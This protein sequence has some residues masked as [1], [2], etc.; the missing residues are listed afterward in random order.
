MKKLTI[1][2]PTYNRSNLLLKLF[3]LLKNQTTYDFVWH[4]IN[5]GSSDNTDK[6]VEEIIA[7]SP[8]QVVY[9]KQINSG[10]MAAWNISIVK[11]NTPFWTCID[12]D[13]EPECDFVAQ[14]VADI[15]S[16][17]ELPQ[18][19]GCA[20]KIFNT[21]TLR[22]ISNFDHVKGMTLTQLEAERKSGGRVGDVFPVYKTLIL[23]KF[24][25]TQFVG[26]RF[27]PE[28][29]LFIRLSVAGYKLQYV[30]KVMCRMKYLSDGYTK[31]FKK[32]FIQNP[33][34]FLYFYKLQ[35]KWHPLWK[36]KVKS[37]IRVIQI[38]YFSWITKINV[39]YL[40]NGREI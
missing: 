18:V 11:T 10:K 21:E 12:D 4:I 37:L 35:L 15:N 8:F 33:R 17:V 27:M 1:F 29:E 16:L 6:V 22:L 25:L 5:D 13:Q 31:N 14:S 30:D 3:G 39:L 36:V 2:T 7:S 28:G 24:P 32:Y 20:Y 26:E 9:D 38:I 34:S 23:K 40:G 19:F